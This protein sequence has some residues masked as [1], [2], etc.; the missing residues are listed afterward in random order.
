MIV[1]LLVEI[2]LLWLST[3]LN[4]F[5]ST[6]QQKLKTRPTILLF[7]K[8]RREPKQLIHTKKNEKLTVR[9]IS[10]IAYIKCLCQMISFPGDHGQKSAQE[11]VFR[12]LRQVDH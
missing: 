4:V 8:K 11:G 12:N 10:Y 7:I 5:L 3:F 2:Q 1:A 9:Q 6:N